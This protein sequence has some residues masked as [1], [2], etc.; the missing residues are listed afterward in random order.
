M[1]ICPTCQQCFEDVHALCAHDQT[2]LVASRPGACVI[3]KKYS[4]DQLLD[5]DLSTSVYAGTLLEADRPVAITLLRTRSVADSDALVRFRR[6]AHTIAHLNTRVNHQHVARTFDYGSLPDGGEA[7]IVT[8]LVA[9]QTLR[10][11]MDEAGQLPFADAVHIARQ[12]VEGLDAAHRC[13]VVHRDLNPANIILGRNS[14]KR[15]E[16]KII[17]FGLA[18]LREQRTLLP[19]TDGAHNH[20][21]LNPLSALAPYVSPE[22]HVGEEPDG[23][24]DLYS[25]GVILYEMLAGRLPFDNSAANIDAASDSEKK[26]EQPLPLSDVRADVPESL[27]Q[28]VMQSLQS[29][30]SS[31]PYSAAEFARLLRM[32][33][34]P[35][36]QLKQNTAAAITTPVASDAD[37]ATV[38]SHDAR[39]VKAVSLSDDALP[40]AAASVLSAFVPSETTAPQQQSHVELEPELQPQRAVV[41]QETIAP[42]VENRSEAQESDP[43]PRKIIIYFDNETIFAEREWD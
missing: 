9:G 12:I 7:F 16:V 18:R 40:P 32:D 1:N 3:G 24:S 21:A 14:Y 2:P 4:L 43:A 25:L 28:L 13:G 15:F 36:T 20:A 41:F 10:E 33:E 22:Q 26:E 35:A 19:A 30:R 31:R 5:Q 29:K 42:I 8:E 11:H 39:A 27:V 37:V 34:H 38:H 6:E 17:D 23:R